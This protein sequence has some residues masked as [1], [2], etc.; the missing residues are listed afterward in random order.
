MGRLDGKVALVTGAARGTG[1]VTARLLAEEGAR[2]VVADILDEL[3]A[4]VAR[5]IGAAAC[6]LHLDVTEEGDW[7][8]AVAETTKQFGPLSVLV[9]NAAVLEVESIA[10]TTVE[11]LTELIHVNQI[12][13]FLGTRAA[14]EPM[15][16]CG[17]GSI[18]NVASVDAMEGGNG[19]V[20]YTSSKWGVR[21]LTKAAAVELGM[22][23]IR[24]N[25]V[26]P[27]PGSQDMV[28]PFVARAIERLKD[29][30]ERLRD[31]PQHPFARRGELIDVARAILFLASDE[32]AFV[33]GVDLSVDGGFTVGKIEPGAPFS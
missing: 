25:T 2:V 3:G 6:F 28:K 20:A 23:N 8:R 31:R 18:V 19:V 12:G 9:N 17:G 13:P 16:A 11:R 26:C 15:K 33:S 22:Y 10:K 30:T 21:G 4:E 7:A 1:A 29:R 24:V 32:S 14:I 27:L 5:E